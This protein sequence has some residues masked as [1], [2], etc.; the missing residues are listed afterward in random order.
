MA[1]RMCFFLLH[2]ELLFDVFVRTAVAYRKRDHFVDANELEDLRRVG[3]RHTSH[4]LDT[5]TSSRKVRTAVREVDHRVSDQLKRH[6]VLETNSHGTLHRSKEDAVDS[7]MTSVR[8]Q[9]TLQNLVSRSA[10]VVRDRVSLI[11]KRGAG[12][13]ST[14][15][16]LWILAATLIT[17]LSVVLLCCCLQ[18]VPP[19]DPDE[20]AKADVAQSKTVDEDPTGESY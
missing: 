15:I 1:L 7:A 19:G 18:S 14:S 8:S 12:Q 6:S 3:A 10:S 4:R 20:P 5:N 16:L 2:Q 9:S 17:S 11:G 13:S